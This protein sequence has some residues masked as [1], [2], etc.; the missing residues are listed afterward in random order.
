MGYDGVNWGFL[1]SAASWTAKNLRGTARTVGRC[2][3]DMITCTDNIKTAIIPL[4]VG[5]LG[6]AVVGGAFFAG[7]SLCATILGCVV[8]GPLI[9]AGT[10]AGV[11]GSY[12]VAQKLWF[13]DGHD[14]YYHPL[15]GGG[16]DETIA[17]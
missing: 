13:E 4:V 12:R 9:A 11:Y 5:A 17:R 2:A 16:H 8:G 10:A 7:A 15:G 14:K 3:F 1:G 6:L